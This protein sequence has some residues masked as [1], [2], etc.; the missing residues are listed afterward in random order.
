MD[1]EACVESSVLTEGH[2]VLYPPV[3]VSNEVDRDVLP[4]VIMTLVNTQRI[5]ALLQTIPQMP[6]QL[7]EVSTADN[8]V[9]NGSLRIEGLT[10]AIVGIGGLIGI[11]IV[12]GT[13]IKSDDRPAEKYLE[14]CSKE[15]L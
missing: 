7:E 9:V 14:L 1:V 13:L 11:T 4:V 12:L 8:L 2:R 5:T 10:L 3:P 15:V 6:G